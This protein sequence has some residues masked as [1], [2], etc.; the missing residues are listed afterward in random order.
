[1]R[2]S[3]IVFLILTLSGGSFAYGLSSGTTSSSDTN[4]GSISDSGVTSGPAAMT[5][6]SSQTAHVQCRVLQDT[7]AGDIQQFINQQI[8]ANILVSQYA[9]LQYEC[10]LA[11]DS[12]LDS[13]D[14]N[15]SRAFSSSCA[16]SN[17]L[18]VVRANMP[19]QATLS[20]NGYVDISVLYQNPDNRNPATVSAQ[21]LG[22]SF[23]SDASDVAVQYNSMTDLNGLSS[24]I[25][26]GGNTKSSSCQVYVSGAH[27]L[28]PSAIC[29]GQGCTP[30]ASVKVD[31]G[32]LMFQAAVQGMDGSFA[33]PK[34][35]QWQGGPDGKGEWSAAPVGQDTVVRA[36]VTTKDNAKN[37]CAV[38]FNQLG[39]GYSLTVNK[40]GDCPYFRAARDYYFLNSANSGPQ[41]GGYPSPL[42]L[43]GFD[44]QYGV[45][46]PD[47]PFRGVLN[48]AAD[49]SGNVSMQGGQLVIPPV[50]NR[51]YSSAVVVAHSLDPKTQ[52]VGDAVYYGL[53][54]PSNYQTTILRTIGAEPKDNDLLVFQFYLAAPQMSGGVDLRGNGGQPYYAFHESMGGKPYDRLIPL[55]NDS[56]MPVF[57]IRIPAR[58]DKAMPVEMKDA[59]TCAFSKP[60]K[61]SDVKA[62]RAAVSV[63][64]FTAETAADLYPLDLLTGSSTG[65]SGS[66]TTSTGSSA[67]QQ[68]WMIYPNFG[69]PSWTTQASA[70]VNL[71]DPS[72]ECNMT[73]LAVGTMGYRWNTASMAW[74]V[75]F[76]D[77]VR[78]TGVGTIVTQDPGNISL[79]KTFLSFLY[80]IVPPSSSTLSRGTGVRTQNFAVRFWGQQVSDIMHDQ[81]PEQGS[82]N[83]LVESFSAPICAGSQFQYDNVSLSWSPLILDSAGQGIKISRNFRRSIGFDISGTGY[84]SYVDWPE[85]T[86]DVAFLVLPDKH[87][88]VTSIRNLFGNSE[89]FANGFEKLKKY[90][91]NKDGVID[92]KDSIYGQLRLWYDRN[93]DGVAQADELVALP[94]QGVKSISLRYTRPG[95]KPTA[96]EKTLAGLYYNDKKHAMMNIEDHYF[97]E[98]VDSKRVSLEKGTRSVASLVA[99]KNK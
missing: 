2:L 25:I 55:V 38:K 95:E 39:K 31:N 15:L 58:S 85:N 7:D 99:K 34:S 98:Y 83:N 74:G 42:S 72:N 50:T 79:V 47:M 53:L 78:Q 41:S 21:T 77:Q 10:S 76:A 40:Y 3:Q 64:H 97:Y 61:A 19:S 44:V 20:K 16:Y 65:S 18:C 89:G 8:S 56:C 66:S 52:K 14:L 49:L 96:E 94:S 81:T 46:G 67:P 4:S 60:F 51:K 82:L 88:H 33:I 36:V 5:S 26:L 13:A 80:G 1:M 30:T 11:P 86:K 87:R 45:S 84:R 29:S 57:Q 73:S 22:L 43:P 37:Y 71:R 63:V 24:P 28:Y 91:R 70:R 68:C 54:D 75:G 27:G 48:A 23:A 69:A 62:G 32:V 35:V 59:T 90:D 17:S 9:L 92:A 12:Q 6:S 93:R